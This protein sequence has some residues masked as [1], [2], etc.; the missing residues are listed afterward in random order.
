MA[1]PGNVNSLV[2]AIV[3]AIPSLSAAYAAWQSKANG[4]ELHTA[5]GRTIG[6]HIDGLQAELAK[7]ADAKLL[8]DA[9][10]ASAA[11]SAIAKLSDGHDSTLTDAADYAAKNL[12]AVAAALPAP[13][14]AGDSPPVRPAP[15]IA[16]PLGGFP[17][18]T[19]EETDVLMALIA[20]GIAPPDPDD[21]VGEVIVLPPEPPAAPTAPDV[22]APAPVVDPNAPPAAAAPD[23]APVAPVEPS[24]SDL[25]GEIPA[26]EVV[27]DPAAPVVSLYGGS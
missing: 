4:R 23:A 19:P 25:A 16:P 22:P 3:V 15:V 11:L 8:A 13:L 7:I 17:V 6:E 21:S 5:S 18:L 2:V 27:P 12:L 26:G 1:N 9:K 14:A 10:L 20:K 24:P